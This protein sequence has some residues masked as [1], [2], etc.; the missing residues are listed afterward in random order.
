M[1]LNTYF[2]ENTAIVLVSY[3]A[4]SG[5]DKDKTT[6]LFVY[7]DNY[8]EFL[9][10]DQYKTGAFPYREQY[11][12]NAASGVGAKYFMNSTY[13]MSNNTSN[14]HRCFP[15]NGREAKRLT[16]IVE[17]VN[18]G[19]NPVT[20]TPAL[21][22]PFQKTTANLTNG[23]RYTHA[24]VPHADAARIGDV[25]GTVNVWIDQSNPLKK[26]ANF[27]A[28]SKGFLSIPVYHVG[29]T[30]GF[31]FFPKSVKNPDATIKSFCKIDYIATLGKP[32]VNTKPTPG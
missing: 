26:D 28:Y 1:S 19:K 13:G 10:T 27:A 29:D 22:N 25:V 5:A 31:D 6:K 32:P 15:T 8:Q 21:V 18:F 23:V 20:A 16:H 12:V 2:N 4:T 3:W 17:I 11:V 9:Q 7:L 24:I 30:A 14:N